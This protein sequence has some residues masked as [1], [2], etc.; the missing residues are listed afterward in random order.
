MIIVVRDPE[1]LHVVRALDSPRRFAGRLDGRQ[2][3][4]DKDCNNRDDYEKFDQGETS[5]IHRV[6][7]FPYLTIRMVATGS[8]IG[9][10]TTLFPDNPLK[11]NPN[12]LGSTPNT[13]MTNETPGSALN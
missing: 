4:C 8:L 3:Q 9:R 10:E 12:P 11:P 1:L 2:Q 5:P 6:T 7:S 13:L